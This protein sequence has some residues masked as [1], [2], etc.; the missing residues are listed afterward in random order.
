MLYFILSYR[1]IRYERAENE[2]LT[3]PDF[4]RLLKRRAVPILLSMLACGILALFLVL[5]ILPAQY[6]AS[7][8]FCVRN[9]ISYEDGITSADI[10][11]CESLTEPC[12]ALISG[13]QTMTLAAQDFDGLSASDLSAMISF[14]DMGAGVFRMSVADGNA[15]RAQAVAVRVCEEAAAQIPSSLN[16]GTLS[17][18]DGVTVTKDSPPAVRGV[19]I[20]LLAGFAVSAAVTLLLDGRGSRTARG[21]KDQNEFV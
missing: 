11:A 12:M 7:T 21:E 9:R 20:G 8:T 2:G 3:I 4:L 6:T 16:A 15:G 17:V 1:T 19:L 13:S 10:A 14:E 18:I 5:Y